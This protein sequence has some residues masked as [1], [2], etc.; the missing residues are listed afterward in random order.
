MAKAFLSSLSFSK[1]GASVCGSIRALT[2]TSQMGC[3]TVHAGI[4]GLGLCFFLV[5]EKETG[6]W[7]EVFSH[8]S[9]AHPISRTID[10]EACRLV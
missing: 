4:I 1:G 8:L 10:V 9:G 3:F 6:L 7:S 5:I 2:C